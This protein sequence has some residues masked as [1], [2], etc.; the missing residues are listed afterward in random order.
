MRF[1]F[2][3]IGA[4]RNQRAMAEY[5]GH[6]ETPE[7]IAA[8][9][10]GIDAYWA[11]EQRQFER[12][13]AMQRERDED[14]AYARNWAMDRKAERE[15]VPGWMLIGPTKPDPHDIQRE[16]ADEDLAYLDWLDA[17]WSGEERGNPPKSRE[18]D[19]VIDGAARWYPESCERP[20]VVERG[21]AGQ[22]TF[23]DWAKAH[24]YTEDD[25][26]ITSNVESRREQRL[27][28]REGEQMVAEL[29]RVAEDPQ[30]ADVQDQ[31]AEMTGYVKRVM[32]LGEREPGQLW[33]S[34]Q[35]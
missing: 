1:R 23:E 2:P 12:Y 25:I 29:D 13:D 19:E 15:E 14:E 9:Q 11:E 27:A 5:L 10:A 21:P 3:V 35:N 32:E 6:E 22:W 34:G 30:Y 8:A 7:E 28:Q 16:R 24:H 20:T 17:E 33:A 26:E 31:I 18:L 4:G